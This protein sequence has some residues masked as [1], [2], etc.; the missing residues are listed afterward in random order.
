M[1][2]DATL[3]SELYNIQ[4]AYAAESV[5]LDKN[6]YFCHID[7]KE[8]TITVPP[9]IDYISVQYDHRSFRLNFEIDRYIN[10]IDLLTQTCVIQWVNNGENGEQMGFHPVVFIDS[11][12]PDKLL[13]T[14]EIYNDATQNS[15]T[16]QF[17][18]VFYSMKTETSFLWCYNT[19]PAQSI[20]KDTLDV[21]VQS[22]SEIKPSILL[23]WNERMR[24]LENSVSEAANSALYYSKQAE[25]WAHGRSDF[26]SSIID[27]AKYYKDMTA[28]IY[29]EAKGT[30]DSEKDNVIIA[31][32]DVRDQGIV[33]I[34]ESKNQA[35]QDISD[36][37]DSAISE[38]EIAKNELLNSVPNYEESIDGLENQLNVISESVAELDNKLGNAANGIVNKTSGNSIVVN[39]SFESRLR[40]LRV[41]GRTEQFTTT[42]KNLFNPENLIQGYFSIGN[43][44]SLSAAAETT[45]IWCEC[46]PNTIYT[47]SKTLGARFYIGYT[48][49]VP[50]L[51]VSVTYI[52]NTESQT[53]LSYTSGDEATYLVAYVHHTKHDTISLEEMLASV[54]IEKGS[55]ATAYET[56]T[57]GI[58]SPNP[59]YPQELVSVANDGAVEVEVYGRNL[60]S[61]LSKDI[62][63]YATNGQVVKGT[64]TR[65]C[66]VN[67]SDINSIYVSGDFSL[68][69]PRGN[70]GG[71]I[72]FGLCQEY[73]T[74][75]ISCK[76][77]DLLNNGAV[78]VS[79]CKYLLVSA[80]YKDDNELLKE[81]VDNSFM[82]S[83]GTQ[84]TPYEPYKGKTLPISTPSGLPG[85][86]VT[87]ASLATYTD[88][89]GNM[90]CADEIDFERGVYVKRVGTVE[91]NPGKIDYSCDV[92]Y[93]ICSE[94][95][96][97]NVSLREAALCTH[98]KYGARKNWVNC[99]SASAYTEEFVFT[100]QE[101]YDGRQYRCLIS[102][103]HGNKVTTEVVGLY[104]GTQ[105]TE[106]SIEIIRQPEDV[107]VAKAGERA[108]VSVEAS[109]EG[110]SYV[111]YYLKPGESDFKKSSTTGATY[112][113]SV[114]EERDGFQ[115]YCVITDENGNSVETDIVTLSIQKVSETGIKITRQPEDVWAETYSQASFKV[116]AEGEGL[117]YQWQYS[118][119]GNSYAFWV[120]S[121]GES[122]CFGISGFTSTDEYRNY[123]T[124]NK[125]VVVYPLL[126][127]IETPL[128]E[129]ELTAY[130]T[131]HTNCPVTTIMN[132]SGAHMEAKYN[133]D[134]K[135]YIDNKFAE[136]QNAIMSLIS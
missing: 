56:Y 136:L 78:D 88:E 122:L 63:L 45:S 47:V 67:V 135:I 61:G 30:I 132:D 100:M 74:E 126:T 31:I 109:G 69:Y 16:I 117:S 97:A 35:L 7:S 115:I 54:Q 95:I 118:L 33:Q 102:D 112:S 87:N 70:E 50:A 108:T 55:V 65:S 6:S 2:Y 14:W 3:L 60:F 26:P 73:P 99:T 84:E 85:I 23:E 106:G 77:I 79:G 38:I 37:K 66:I 11:S 58:P 53:S 5:E 48:T 129:E 44:T 20:I 81:A 101:R 24:Y 34:S 131:L 114:T 39:D 10:N 120:D 9:E 12:I 98:F 43:T 82:F 46:E 93:A 116:E 18:V 62:T 52:A 94:P 86:P 29:D 124:N 125:V 127:P 103:I 64:Y 89:D 75:G 21:V 1:A 91:V 113:V 105:E 111:W 17:A 76:R 51:G 8:R 36:V 22:S 128:S 107:E 104:C 123:F 27:N 41:F 80:R 4:R 119:D 121:L 110:L 19:L 59:Q 40:G 83:I 13:F 71:Y 96:N 15:G 92:D 68:L 133:A 32:N 25:A 130:R 72:Y 90:W 134:T 42:G 28:A 57:G 49:E